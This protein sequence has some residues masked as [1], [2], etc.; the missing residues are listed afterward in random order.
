MAKYSQLLDQSSYF[1]L[2]KTEISATSDNF[3]KP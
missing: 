3:Q 2:S 1:I